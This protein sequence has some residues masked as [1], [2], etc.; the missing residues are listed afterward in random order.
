MFSDS[1]KKYFVPQSK[2]D[3]S[4]LSQPEARKPIRQASVLPG[5]GLEL[6]ASLW[7]SSVARKQFHRT[8]T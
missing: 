2:K 3:K 6:T 1:P 4:N 8:P 7:C 5:A